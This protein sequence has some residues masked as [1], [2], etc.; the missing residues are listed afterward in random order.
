MTLIHPSAVI[1]EDTRIGKGVAV[2]ANAVINSGSVV[3]DGCIINTCASVDH[4]NVISAYTHISVDAHTAGTV[5]IGER[6][7][8]GIGASL[9]N[10]IAICDDVIIGAGSVVVDNITE[11]GI[12]YGVP[13][14]KK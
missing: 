11:S 5:R 9:I 4:D 7:M 14:R 12:Y 2:M 3:K 6:C 8:V 10:N 13:A 1:A